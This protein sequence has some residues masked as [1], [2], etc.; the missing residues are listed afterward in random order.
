MQHIDT[1]NFFCGLFLSLICG[2]WWNPFTRVVLMHDDI[3]LIGYTRRIN[4]HHIIQ[5]LITQFYSVIFLWSGYDFPVDACAIFTHISQR[6]FLV[7]GYSCTELPHGQEENLTIASV[8]GFALGR[9]WLK[10]N[11]NKMDQEARVMGLKIAI[12]YLD[13]FPV[14]HGGI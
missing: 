8:P 11:H 2:T 9:I 10:S 5:K 6:C 4:I 13:R 14:H 1:S 3:I 12:G 7:S